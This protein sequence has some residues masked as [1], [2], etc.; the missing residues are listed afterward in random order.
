MVAGADLFTSNCM[1]ATFAV[2]EGGLSCRQLGRGGVC[3]RTWLTGLHST[4]ACLHPEPAACTHLSPWP[5]PLHCR[6]HCAAGRY[7]LLG[8]ARCLLTSYAA[9]L[10]GSLLLIA[11]MLG[12]EVFKGREA[13]VVE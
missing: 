5:A 3:G 12:G 2:S 10:A 8:A 1:Y 4:R 6:R 9:N 11:L 13:F 7:G